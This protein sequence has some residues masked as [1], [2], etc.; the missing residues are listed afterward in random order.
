MIASVF[1]K[2]TSKE[3]SCYS[4]SEIGDRTTDRLCFDANHSENGN[5]NGSDSIVVVAA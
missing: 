5:K 4:F 3:T 1:C 2:F